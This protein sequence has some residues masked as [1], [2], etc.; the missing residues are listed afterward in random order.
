MAYNYSYDDVIGAANKFG[1][2]LSEYDD[3]LAKSNPNAGMSIVN[4]KYGWLNATT[5]EERAAYN[6]SAEQT[7]SKF[8][9]Y[10]GGSW[11]NEYNYLGD[12][13]S[14]FTPKTAPVYNKTYSGEVTGAYD[15]LKNYGNYSY[16]AEKPVYNDRYS[17]KA[18]A[19]IDNIVN[20]GDFSYDA[21]EDPSY[22]AY[23][24]AYTREGKRATADALGEAAS[25]TG[26]I[27]S[28]YAVTSASQAGDYYASKLADKIPELYENAYKR[29]LNE[30]SKLK[31]K[32][33]IVSEAQQNEYNKYLNDLNQYNNDR[34]FDYQTYAD[35]Y[36]RLLNRY[37]AAREAENDEYT[38][39]LNELNQ[40]NNDRSFDYGQF[41]DNLNY[42]DNRALN[43]IEEKRTAADAALADAETA[44]KYGDF[45]RLKELGINTDAYE[46]AYLKGLADTAAGSTGSAASGYGL[47]D[48]LDVYK[49][50]GDESLLNAL[51]IYPT[52][53]TS[54]SPSYSDE[55][56]A[57]RLGA[58]Q[59]LLNKG[60]VNDFV[61]SVYEDYFGIPWNTLVAAGYVT[62]P[63]TEQITDQT[64]DDQT[65]VSDSYPETLQAVR[66]R[67]YAGLNPTVYNSKK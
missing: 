4:D 58:A 40:Y 42:I 21:S 32:Y 26:G 23:K 50:T 54:D 61:I 3:A 31:S 13:P 27:P 62:L 8:G 10:T 64:P 5:D 67:I 18:D 1:I 45:S 37:E 53:E 24:K 20:Y 34:S 29:Y 36:S 49:K 65:T 38:K 55:Q 17:D 51:G 11:G 35:E 47:S 2:T 19:L 22:T 25:A 7:R 41:I 66:D 46:R 43:D 28:S 56:K 33:G 6:Q 16:G 59:N 12:T 57:Y 14:S 48:A 15:A 39:Y 9:N 60:I 63:T 30:F 52:E 44:A